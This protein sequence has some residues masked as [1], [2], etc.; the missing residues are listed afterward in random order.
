[1]NYLELCQDIASELGIAGG[2]G[3]VSVKGQTGELKN[4]TRWIADATLWIDNLWVDWKYL[5]A[6][7]DVDV[8]TRVL[9]PPPS[10]YR[11]RR[12]DRSAFWLNYQTDRSRNLAWVEYPEFRALYLA[13]PERDGVPSR[14]TIAPDNSVIFDVL[15]NESMPVHAEFWRKPVRLLEN[16]DTPAIPEE[17]HRIIVARAAIMYG[18]REAAGEIISGMEAEYIDLLEKLQ[19]SQLDAFA[20]DRM[21]GQDLP[22][23][24]SG[25]S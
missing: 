6:S 4:V 10:G 14:F 1:M 12:W 16:T 20:Q 18:N 24:L 21:A 23:Q 22:M 13:R 7:M 5:W 11:V 17:F 9:P 19:G 3:P 25:P 2:S 15:P 8:T